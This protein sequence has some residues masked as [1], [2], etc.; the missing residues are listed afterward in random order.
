MSNILEGVMQSLGQEGVS[1]IASRLGINPSQA[2]TAV[3]SALPLIV[4]A[5]AKNST[6][7]EGADAL[8]NALQNHSNA[9]SI[10]QQAQQAGQGDSSLLSEGSAILGHI[11]GQRQQAATNGVAQVSGLDNSG[12]GSLLS[13]LAPMV[14]GY[15]GKELAGKG[16]NAG[17]LSNTLGQQ[18]GA[19]QSGGGITSSLLSSVLDRN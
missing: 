2:T 17:Q 5:M 12:A 6:S 1:A 10:A 15:V 4:G 16:M 19:M 18:T 14:M 11:F 8:H 3:A 7:T 13:M 9:P